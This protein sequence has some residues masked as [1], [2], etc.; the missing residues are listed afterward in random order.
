MLL[1]KSKVH[2][3]IIDMNLKHKIEKETINMKKIIFLIFIIFAFSI[4]LTINVY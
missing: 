2:Y 3:K 1:K 4:L